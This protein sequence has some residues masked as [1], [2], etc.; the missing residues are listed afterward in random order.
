MKLKKPIK[1]VTYGTKKMVSRE[2]ISTRVFEIEEAE[3]L[4]EK[5]VEEIQLIDFL[6]KIG[7]TPD[8]HENLDNFSI[9]FSTSF[10]NDTDYLTVR[11]VEYAEETEAAMIVTG[12]QIL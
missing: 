3:N 4:D 10:E 7:I 9:N 1:P 6:Y 12:K 11:T 2:V 5:L 8:K